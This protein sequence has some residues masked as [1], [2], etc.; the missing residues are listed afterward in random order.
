MEC[1]CGLACGLCRLGRGGPELRSATGGAEVVVVVLIRPLYWCHGTKVAST[2]A[3]RPRPESL[4]P[5]VARQGPARCIAGQRAPVK[6]PCKCCEDGMEKCAICALGPGTHR[7]ACSIVTR[8][9]I[10]MCV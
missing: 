5:G 1:G 2:V 7:T 6:A 3:A 8:R 10:S 4:C 9:A